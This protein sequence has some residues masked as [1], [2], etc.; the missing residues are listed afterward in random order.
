VTFL[1]T[2][3]SLT[4][5][6]LSRPLTENKTT[7]RGESNDDWKPNE[8]SDATKEIITRVEK[9]ANEIG[10]SMAQVS[11][12]WQMSKSFC[13]APIIGTTSLEKLQDCI[14]SIRVKLTEEQIRFIDEPYQP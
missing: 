9:V 2:V 13:S 10:V 12:A 7:A 5:S 4:H 8:L 1:S 14:K 3:P 6:D 11:L